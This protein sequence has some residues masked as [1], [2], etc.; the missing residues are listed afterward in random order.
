MVGAAYGMPLGAVIGDVTTPAASD[1]T[2]ALPVSSGSPMAAVTRLTFKDGSS[3]AKDRE[4]LI[5]DLIAFEGAY[6]VNFA[7]ADGE[8][9]VHESNLVAAPSAQRLAQLSRPSRP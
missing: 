9:Y 1:A 5:T 8:C 7:G 3:I 2:R 4:G 6:W